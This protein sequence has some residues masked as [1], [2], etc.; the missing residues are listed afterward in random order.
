MVLVHF[1]VCFLNS[2]NMYIHDMT[3]SVLIHTCMHDMTLSVETHTHIH[4][5]TLS[6]ETQGCNPS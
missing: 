2:G 1:L 5:V 3:L 4:D 6:V